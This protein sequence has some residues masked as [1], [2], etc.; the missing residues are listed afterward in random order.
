[1]YFLKTYKHCSVRVHLNITV[2][3]LNLQEFDN[4]A[5]K[6]QIKEIT[7]RIYELLFK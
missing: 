5:F 1:M 6:E 2:E 3:V 7:M 4:D